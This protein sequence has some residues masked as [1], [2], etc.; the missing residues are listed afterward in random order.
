MFFFLILYKYS[1][2]WLQLS[3]ESFSFMFW[4]SLHNRNY[5]ELVC[6]ASVSNSRCWA[7]NVFGMTCFGWKERTAICSAIAGF[8]RHDIAAAC[9][10]AAY[11]GCE[12]HFGECGGAK[13]SQWRS[14]FTDFRFLL[15]MVFLFSAVPGDAR[16]WTLDHLHANT[17][18]TTKLWFPLQLWIIPQDCVLLEKSCS[19]KKV[20]SKK[21]GF[22][23]KKRLPKNLF[24]PTSDVAGLCVS[25]GGANLPTL[26][27]TAPLPIASGDCN[28][29]PIRCKG[30][31]EGPSTDKC[32]M[33]LHLVWAWAV[34]LSP[35]ILGSWHLG[36]ST[37][38]ITT[39]H[40][41]L[42]SRAFH[43]ATQCLAIISLKSK[44]LLLFLASDL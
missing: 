15:I 39:A 19:N 27:S 28:L 31:Q 38:S 44:V 22:L 12:L 40:Y 25:Q 7:Q 41:L 26:C 9:P 35:S 8:G 34:H 30:G 18:S 5:F 1:N 4:S 2:S 16:D 6:S 17:Y 29:Q 33:E 14:Y 37:S 43:F 13:L 20:T 32:G 42:V 21:S 3:R 24:L 11:Q 36:Q 10:L 23:P